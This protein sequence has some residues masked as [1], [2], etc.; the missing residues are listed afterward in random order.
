[1]VMG[2]VQKVKEE[3]GKFKR[4]EPGKRFI[5]HYQR[6]QK[7]KS[8]GKTVL[9]IF[10][11]LLLLA[12]GIFMWFVPGPG[13]LFVFFGLAMFAGESHP[14]ATFLDKAE[15]R[16]R[17]WFTRAKRFWHHAHA[18]IKAAIAGG[19]VTAIGAVCYGAWMILF[20]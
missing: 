1:M 11:G 19:L 15:L 3:W 4:D 14:I 12:A 18:G 10:V 6:A 5:G 9:R 2:V 20:K 13:W 17:R 16:L 7:N 8:V